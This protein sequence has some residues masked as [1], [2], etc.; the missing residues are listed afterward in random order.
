MSLVSSDKACAEYQDG[1]LVAPHRVRRNLVFCDAKQKNVLTTVAIS[2][3]ATYGHPEE[4]T[5]CTSPM[6]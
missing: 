5:I 6:K 3:T 2:A 1:A 4:A